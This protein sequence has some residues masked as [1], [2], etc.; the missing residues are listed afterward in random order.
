MIELPPVKHG[1]VDLAAILFIIGGVAS[2][3]VSILTIP[4][5]YPVTAP[6]SFTTIPS[7]AIAITLVCSLGA[8]CCYYLAFKRILSEAAIR[9]IAFGALLLIFSLGLTG[10][11]SE[12]GAYTTLAAVSSILVLVAGTICFA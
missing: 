1:L 5:I 9:G 11:F 7:V 6:A 12:S 10:A 8:I 3:V 4:I 2:L